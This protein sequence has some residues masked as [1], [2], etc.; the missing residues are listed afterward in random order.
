ML[1]RGCLIIV[2]GQNIKK[3]GF[4]NFHFEL[5]RVENCKGS[6]CPSPN[7]QIG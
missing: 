5:P 2:N 7:T 3:I 1:Y 4:R 6:L